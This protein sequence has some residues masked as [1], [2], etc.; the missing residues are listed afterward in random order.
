MFVFSK[1]QFQQLLNIDETWKTDT[2]LDTGSGD[3]RVTA[4]MEN[5]FTNIYVMEQSPS[6][7]WRLGQKNYHVLEIDEWT[8]RT[9]DVISCLNLLDRCDKPLTLLSDIK[10]ALNPNGG[11]LI[12]AVV[13]PFK[14]CVESGNDVVISVT[15]PILDNTQLSIIFKSD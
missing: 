3:G 10:N 15:Y 1:R 4:V 14:P 6:M 11:R 8:T 7:R 9:Y 12:V 5:H 13:L 2:L